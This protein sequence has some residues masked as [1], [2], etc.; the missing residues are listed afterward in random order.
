MSPSPAEAPPAL[1][2]AIERACS[3]RSRYWLHLHR[4]R[5]PTSDHEIEIRIDV[6][7]GV[8][9][10]ITDVPGWRIAMK[11]PDGRLFL[12]RSQPLTNR[13]VGDM[14]ADAVRLAHAYG[15]RFH[16]WTHDRQMMGRKVSEESA[17]T[18][19]WQAKSS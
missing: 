9:A 12:R 16:A 18:T 7:P 11:F 10:D 14:I 13:A 15:G 19:E 8:V 2:A 3:R 6:G 5:N 1:A 4:P 17:R